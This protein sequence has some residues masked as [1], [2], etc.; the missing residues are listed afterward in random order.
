[1]ELKKKTFNVEI[2]DL[3]EEDRS[4]LAVASTEDVDRDNDRIMAA[5]W[6]LANFKKNPVIPWA[7]RY[8]D[9]P[10]A[11]AAD[12]YVEGGRLM[13]KPKFASAGEYPFADTIYKLYKGGFL[14]SFSVGFRPKR[15]EVVERGKNRGFDIIEQELW[16]ISA[17]T[18]PANPNALVAAKQKGVIDDAEMALF[19]KMGNDLPDET[20][21]EQRLADIEQRLQNLTAQ[22]AL[23]PEQI[24]SPELIAPLTLDEIETRLAALEAA[25]KT[26]TPAP[27]DLP[28][29]TPALDKAQV[30]AIASQAAAAAVDRVANIIAKRIN[31]HLGKVE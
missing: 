10:V 12:V 19:K 26:K 1:M 31:Y 25:G 15:Y 7:H 28:P 20:D 8:G 18:V 14:N 23:L 21:I 22:F 3:N 27:E 24:F 2:K 11:K 30:A 16:E 17:C 13:F 29:A 5:G 4:F 9:P 6:D